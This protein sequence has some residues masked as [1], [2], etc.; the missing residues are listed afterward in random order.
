MRAF[1]SFNIEEEKKKEISIIQNNVRKY[2]GQKIAND[3]KW[4]ECDK[5]HQT[6]FFL[7]DINE[8]QLSAI[9][10]NLEELKSKINFKELVFSASEINAFPNLKYP[11][12]LFI[13][14]LNE[15]QKVFVLFDLICG[16][17]K[18]HKFKPDK[19]FHPHITLG[20]V[21]RDKKINL[22]ELKDK[23]NFELKI[24]ADAFYL[25]ESKLGSRG[26]TYNEI[27]KFEL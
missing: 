12:V 4:E 19:K 26:S 10:N 9:S 6:L 2:I 21:K 16:V 25:M 22:S 7:G 5:F 17:L 8:K 13:E 14:L 20:R 1:I 11:R 27:K 3:I 23:I 15:N 24:S 18:N